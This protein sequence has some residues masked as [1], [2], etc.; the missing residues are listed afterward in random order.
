MDEVDFD[1][2]ETPRDI[3]KESPKGFHKSPNR[4]ENIKNTSKHGQLRNGSKYRG[5]KEEE[6]VDS[7]SSDENSATPRVK[8]HSDTSKKGYDRRSVS[9][10]SESSSA[11]SNTDISSDSDSGDEDPNPREK[12]SIDIHLPSSKMQAWTSE[13]SSE[14]R[15]S[16]SKDNNYQEQKR[17]KRGKNR[18]KSGKYD[19][20][21]FESDDSYDKHENKKSTSKNRAKSAKNRDKKNGNS[22]GRKI[23]SASSSFSN[24]SD[25]TDVSPLDSPE[26][27]PRQ[28]RQQNAKSENVQYQ[29]NLSSEKCADIKLET[30]E[31]DLSILMKCMAD[32]DR[33]KQ[34]RLKSNSRRVMFE[35]PASDQ[36]KSNYTFSVGRAKMIEK[37]NQRLLKQIMA[38]MNTSGPVKK[39]TSGTS[40][41]PK[42]A[43]A[44]AVNRM[45]PSAV[46]RMREQR[47]IEAE[48]QVGFKRFT[49]NVF[50]YSYL[51]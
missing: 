5:R 27:S 21:S 34:M 3:S 33:E 49:Y 51:H 31:I 24:N 18:Q 42:K 2:F 46:N 47:R 23:M 44:P 32:I 26:N 29:D 43:L 15:H 41:G 7:S 50:V 20:D 38:Q 37:E 28:K 9:S 48:N 1:F 30:D 6:N 13:K 45:T 12:E 35:P 39:T 8:A 10:G 19:S 17:S 14:G 25:I 22:H 40:R 11:Y 36:S 16:K 4:E